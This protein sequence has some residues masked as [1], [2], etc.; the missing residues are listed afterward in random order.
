MDGWDRDF[1]FAIASHQH[2][3]D[4]SVFEVASYR[5]RL[6][7]YQGQYPL[8]LWPS[9]VRSRDLSHQL[10]L[11]NVRRQGLDL[12]PSACK[13]GVLPLSHALPPDPW[14]LRGQGSVFLPAFPHTSD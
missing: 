6:L 2:E 8:C 4:L 11:F 9:K 1:L 5:V 13:A 7:V 12:E 10:T 3:V 14:F